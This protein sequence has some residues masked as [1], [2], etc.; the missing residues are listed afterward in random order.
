MKSAAGTN[1]FVI[2]DAAERN[3]RFSYT[4]SRSSRYRQ[5]DIDEW[6]SGTGQG[7]R[8]SSVTDVRIWLWTGIIFFMLFVLG[9]RTAYLQ[10]IEGSHFRS[11]AEGNRIRIR[12]IKATRGILYDRNQIPL[13]RNEPSVSL[14]VVPVDLPTDKDQRTALFNELSAMAS[15][16]PDQI[17]EQVK[18]AA[19]YSYQPLILKENLT[20]E[21][22]VLTEILSSRY[23]GVALRSASIRQYSNDVGGL[24]L[25]HILGYV[26]RIEEGKIESYIEKGYSIDDYV[27]KAGIEITYEKELKGTNGREQVEVDA[28]G[29][30]KEILASEKAVPGSNII[31]TIDAELQKV[32][33]QSLSRQLVGGLERGVVIALN[34]QNGEVLALVSLPSYDHNVFSHG[35]DQK[36]FSELINDP[37]RPLFSRA[38]SGEYASGSTIKMIKAAAALDAGIIDRRTSFSSVGGISVGQWFFPDW[39]AGG[40]GITNVT[41]ALAESVNTFFYII[42]G[43]YQQFN[44]LGIERMKQ[45]AEKFGPDKPL[46]VDLPNE[47]SGFYPS[48][49]WKEEA[50]HEQWY[51]GDTYHAAIGQ[52]DVLVTPLQVAAYTSVFAN[53]GTLYRPHIAREFLATET[54]P[55]KHVEPDVIFKNVVSSESIAIVNDGLRQAVTDGSARRLSTLPFQSAAKTGTAQWSST[56]QPHAWATSFAPFKEPQI[57]VTVL[58]EEGKEGSSVAI[59]VINDILVWWGENRLNAQNNEQ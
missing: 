30:A 16:T 7:P 59:P 37:N 21:Q 46:G 3:T 24:S 49:Q 36:T 39:K 29:E 1:P 2:G 11:V 55:D 14:S 13:V 15:S 50:K 20:H 17:E 22:A 5:R 58:I 18:K 45:Y 33:E 57:V 23:P 51:I 54:Q 10:L 38:V 9:G 27:G 52:G 19:Q 34:P 12:D 47:A 53:G 56:K 6:S 48:E 8:S 40:H 44:G 41:K 43:G 42:G 35:V 28:T 25:S 4:V 26:G 31:L 32:A